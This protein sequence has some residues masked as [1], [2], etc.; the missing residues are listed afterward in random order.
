MDFIL[1]ADDEAPAHKLVYLQAS[2]RTPWAWETYR[3]Q[4]KAVCQNR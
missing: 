1:G 4:R 3:K 2:L